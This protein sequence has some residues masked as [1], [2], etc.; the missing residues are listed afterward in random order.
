MLQHVYHFH[1]LQAII[2]VHEYI[3]QG[4]RTTSKASIQ[5]T[6]KMAYHLYQFFQLF[7]SSNLIQLALNDM[8]D[9]KI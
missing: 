3:V 7:F 2:W 9:L 6:H 5:P 1:K 8:Y 4:F